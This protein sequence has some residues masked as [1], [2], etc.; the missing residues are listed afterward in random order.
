V[1]FFLEK[2]L[3]GLGGICSN[4]LRLVKFSEYLIATKS[5]EKVYAINGE[6]HA[7]CFANLVVY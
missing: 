4:V 5:M 7:W 3:T 6:F 2:I 1:N